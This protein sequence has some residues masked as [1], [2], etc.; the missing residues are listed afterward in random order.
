LRLTTTVCNECDPHGAGIRI[1]AGAAAALVKVAEP[2]VQARLA[3]F[4]LRVFR[5]NHDY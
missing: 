2:L 1:D 4:E 3:T 5:T